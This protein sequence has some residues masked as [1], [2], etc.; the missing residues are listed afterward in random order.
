MRALAHPVRLAIL[1]AMR[2]EGELTATRA[3]Q[4]LGES[5]GNMSWH[6]QT[7]AKYGFII[8]AE[9]RK[10][11][12]RP[13]RIA[14]GSSRIS[15]T[16]EEPGSL[17]AAEHLA[18]TLLDRSVEQLKEWWR[19][20]TEF[21]AAWFDAS[22]IA[23][24]TTFLTAAELTEIGEQMLELRRTFDDRRDP[25]RR[26]DDAVPVHMVSFAHPMPRRMHRGR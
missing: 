21:D 20:R 11:R 14:E 16:E 15:P 26:P 23:E 9:G 24:G 25:A 5:P 17:D 7:L 12:S 8:E 13:W 10:G 18:A 22:F 2:D 19:Q 1:D 3:A 6:L 4:L